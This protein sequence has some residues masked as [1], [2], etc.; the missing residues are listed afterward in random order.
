MKDYAFVFRQTPA[1]FTAEQQAQRAKDVAAWATHLRDAGHN[2]R[3]FL[4]G[5]E[6]V[7]LQPNGDSSSTPTSP[8]A[9]PIVAI[10]IANFASLD[11]AHQAA[12]THPGLRY[13]ITIEIREATQ[14][15][16]QT[17]PPTTVQPSK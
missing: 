3:P 8:S 2:M 11:D 5:K 4:L 10:L 6:A 14:P 16:F 17:P 12:A 7:L 9:D 13:G 1:Q 15:Q